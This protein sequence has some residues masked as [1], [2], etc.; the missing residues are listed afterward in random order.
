MPAITGTIVGILGIKISQTTSTALLIVTGIFAAFFFQ[1]SV[2]LL[3][4][5]A[6]WADTTPD[7]K[8]STS[9]YA[10]LLEG[11]S[12]NSIYAALI[13]V[14][15]TLSIVFTI[16]THAK[17]IHVTLAAASTA[18]LAHLAM[19]LLLVASRVF[20]LTRARLNA[21]RTGSEI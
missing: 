12:A 15:A 10:S 3:D 18:L 16:I 4:R 11:L 9:Q 21:A 20:S 5:A 13:A 7:P 8:P 6:N 14:L 17:S 19:T 1:L 2:Q